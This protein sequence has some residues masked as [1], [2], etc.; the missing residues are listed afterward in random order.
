MCDFHNFGFIF[1]GQCTVCLR[2]KNQRLLKSFWIER[3]RRSQP[4]QKKF[5]KTLILA[6][7]ANSALSCEN[8]TKIVKITHSAYV[9]DKQSFV[10]WFHL[11]YPSNLLNNVCALLCTFYVY[12]SGNHL[13]F[14]YFKCYV[15]SIEFWT[16][17]CSVE[18]EYMYCHNYPLFLNYL[19]I[20]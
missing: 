16:I 18:P 10:C 12:Y 13:L 6:F 19:L 1:A 17:K 14:D 11:C 8:E 4:S 9:T 20:N 3:F 15:W 7:E 2:D 5:Q